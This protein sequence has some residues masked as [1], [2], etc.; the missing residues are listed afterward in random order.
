MIRSYEHASGT[1]V[2]RARV[3]FYKVLGTVKMAVISLTGVRSYCEAR[4]AE[5]TLAVVGLL[6]GRLSTEL[7]QLLDVAATAAEVR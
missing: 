4:S 6:I 5:P 2:D 7:L 3:H 1:T